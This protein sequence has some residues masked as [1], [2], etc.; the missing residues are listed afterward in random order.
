MVMLGQTVSVKVDITAQE[1][2]T[3]QLLL[4]P[5][6]LK[7]ISVTCDTCILRSFNEL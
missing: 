3:P 2:T 6:V 5:F 7:V 1:E 4:I